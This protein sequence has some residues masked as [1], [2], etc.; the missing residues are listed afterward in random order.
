MESVDKLLL[1]IVLHNT[2]YNPQTML[3]PFYSWGF[4]N[5][6]FN[7]SSHTNT[8]QSYHILQT[9][10]HLLKSWQDWPKKLDLF[11]FIHIFYLLPNIIPHQTNSRPKN[12]D[13][14]IS[15]FDDNNSKQTERTIIPL[16]HN[17]LQTINPNTK[18]SI[19][20][21]VRWSILYCHQFPAMVLGLEYI[22]KNQHQHSFL[23]SLVYIFL[24][25]SRK[26]QYNA[27][28]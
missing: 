19:V 26:I 27:F 10:I 6:F 23:Q 17:S 7:N 11:F 16:I 24:H 8:Q 20:G 1:A 2:L 21:F 18:C 5:M 13:L 3:H 12:W 15:S 25:N 4:W 14:V 22:R 28:M 9:H